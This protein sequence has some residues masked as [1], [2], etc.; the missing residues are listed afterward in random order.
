MVWKELQDCDAVPSRAVGGEYNMETGMCFN[1]PL[2]IQIV[3]CKRDKTSND[4]KESWF[5]HYLKPFI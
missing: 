4:S 5:S 2:L 3:F 1:N